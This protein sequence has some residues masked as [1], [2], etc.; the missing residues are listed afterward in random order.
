MIT[1]EMSLCNNFLLTA[2]FKLLAAMPWW[3][4]FLYTIEVTGVGCIHKCVIQHLAEEIV[5]IWIW[6]GVIFTN[7]TS[8]IGRAHV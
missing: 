5:S 4:L 6:L 7:L 2:C 8:K 1:H 3:N